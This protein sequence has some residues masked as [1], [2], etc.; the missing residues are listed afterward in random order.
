MTVDRTENRQN[1][2]A[3]TFQ[4]YELTIRPFVPLESRG[5]ETPPCSLSA[6]DSEQ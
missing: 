2:E 6:N 1:S 5:S 4:I 3:T